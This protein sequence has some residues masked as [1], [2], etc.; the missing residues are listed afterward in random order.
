M[1][2]GT[3]FV[4]PVLPFPASNDKCSCQPM[5]GKLINNNTMFSG[6]YGDFPMKFVLRLNNK[7]DTDIVLEIEDCNYFYAVE[8]NLDRNKDG[9]PDFLGKKPTDSISPAAAAGVAGAISA[10]VAGTVAASVG[11]AIGSSIGAG[12]AAG[13]AAGAAGGALTPLIAQA[14]F[15]GIVGQIGG[16]GALPAS[17]SGLSDGIQT[18]IRAHVNVARAHTHGHATDSWSSGL[19]WTNFNLPFGFYES[20]DP[21][22]K[23]RRQGGGGQV[24]AGRRISQKTGRRQNANTAPDKCKVIATSKT[25]LGAKGTSSLIAVGS[26]F[27]TRVTARVTGIFNNDMDK[28]SQV[29]GQGV[30][31]G[32]LQLLGFTWSPLADEKTMFGVMEMA[33]VNKLWQGISESAAEAVNSGCVKYFAWGIVAYIIQLLMVISVVY[34]LYKAITADPP[35]IVF[36]WQNKPKI[37]PHGMPLHQE[38]HPSDI[39]AEEAKKKVAEEAKVRLVPEITGGP[40]PALEPCINPKLNPKPD[41]PAAAIFLCA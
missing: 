36:R 16:K 28:L 14:Q 30:V 26:A 11:A 32:I 5:I 19:G 34:L 39:A 35:L 41:L 37:G 13:G 12:G 7:N 27:G 1:F 33:V 31:G 38:L 29:G 40:I 2:K 15:L 9:K 18:H 23:K 4:I 8:E 20:N 10:V 3:I 22:T 24:L 6:S 17:S 25:E 21:R